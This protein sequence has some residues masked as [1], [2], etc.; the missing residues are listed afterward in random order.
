MSIEC[1][2]CERDM[3]SGHAPDCKRPKGD[4][5]PACPHCYDDATLR[6]AICEIA[7]QVA[8]GAQS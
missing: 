4:K 5:L 8:E 1:G 7:E 3:R 6:R 2:Y